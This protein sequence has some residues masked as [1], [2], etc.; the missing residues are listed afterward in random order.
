VS[1]ERRSKEAER[2]PQLSKGPD[3]DERFRACPGGRSLVVLGTRETKRGLYQ[4]D[5]AT[6]Q[7]IEI[8]DAGSLAN[9]YLLE[10]TP[11]WKWVFHRQG[12]GKIARRDT[13]SGEE[14][15][16][17][18]AEQGRQ[19]NFYRVSPDDKQLA[20]VQDSESGEAIL[21]VPA[22]GGPAKSL[23]T[24]DRKDWRIGY[25]RGS[26]AWSRDGKYILF[27]RV[28]GED[29]PSELWMVS[30]DGGAAR[31]TGLTISGRLGW[32][33]VHPDA[34]RIAYMHF[35]AVIEYW[36]AENFLPHTK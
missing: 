17:Y 27:A 36:I 23:F 31:N 6:G 29:R 9:S 20:F 15:L 35:R 11:D 19:N 25:M 14:K 3:P 24:N 7:A 4:V 26:L 32:I 8:W 13:G 18:R 21:S 22:E 33:N 16:I 2:P 34:T 1:F 12:G 30:S 5:T 10:W 28:A